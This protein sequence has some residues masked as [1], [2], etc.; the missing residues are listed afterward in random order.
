M[1]DLICLLS[2]V[3]THILK[4]FFC[5]IRIMFFKFKFLIGPINKNPNKSILI[6]KLFFPHQ[7]LQKKHIKISMLLF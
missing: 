5:H 2:I 6:K 1:S 4:Y 7:I 3:L